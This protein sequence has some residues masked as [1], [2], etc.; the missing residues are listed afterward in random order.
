MPLDERHPL[1]ATVAVLTSASD[2]R[3]MFY[4]TLRRWD[5]DLANLMNCLRDAD[6]DELKMRQSIWHHGA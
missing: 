5:D 3:V 2:L 1:L 6:R 4:P